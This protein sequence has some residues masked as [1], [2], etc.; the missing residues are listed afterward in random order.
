M[1]AHLF[2]YAH[3]LL[4]MVDPD[5]VAPGF[6]ERLQIASAPTAHAVPRTIATPK[7]L[8]DLG[9]RRT[10]DPA[11]FFDLH[12]QIFDWPAHHDRDATR[13]LLGMADQTDLAALL[14]AT[15]L[16]TGDYALAHDAVRLRLDE[17]AHGDD[18]QLAVTVGV[19]LAAMGDPACLRLLQHA[20]AIATDFRTRFIAQ[21]RYAAAQIKRV[22][23]PAAGVRSLDELDRSIEAAHDARRIT[24]NDQCSL[25]A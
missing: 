4:N 21:H 10:P 6:V 7:F 19:L 24:F 18:A 17:I 15:V 14:D 3:E 23:D 5:A 22:N 9:L 20:A 8:T 11:Q 13:A 2:D 25:T 16:L 12:L 1:T